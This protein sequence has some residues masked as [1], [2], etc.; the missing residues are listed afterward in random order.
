LIRGD[1]GVVITH[2]FKASSALSNAGRTVAKS[3]SHSYGRKRSLRFQKS[4]LTSGDEGVVITH[5][6]STINAIFTG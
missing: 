4:F 1:E 5:E 6:L 3:L 2:D